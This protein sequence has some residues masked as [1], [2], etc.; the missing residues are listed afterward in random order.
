[1]VY[2]KPA[3]PAKV[4]RRKE[5]QMNMKKLPALIAT[6]IVALFG[7]GILAAF[8]VD[9]NKTYDMSG[10][11]ALDTVLAVSVFLFFIGVVTTACVSIYETLTDNYDEI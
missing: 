7:F 11:T 10:M 3:A 6:A 9:V 5:N 8:I 2:N 1:M 4:Q